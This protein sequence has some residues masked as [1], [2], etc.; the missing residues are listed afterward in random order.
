MITRNSGDS[1]A[2]VS[3]GLVADN[4]ENSICSTPSKCISVRIPRASS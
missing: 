1:F 3:F 2:H 4:K